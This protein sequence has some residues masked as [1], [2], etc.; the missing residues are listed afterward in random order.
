[1]A[2]I[3]CR[4]HGTYPN[5]G[6]RSHETNTKKTTNY[7]NSY[8]FFHFMPTGIQLRVESFAYQQQLLN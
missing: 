3:S 2:D 1:M 4:L 7:C 8:D 5:N 6:L